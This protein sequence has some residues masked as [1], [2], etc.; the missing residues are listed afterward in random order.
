VTL[1]AV[2]N[3]QYEVSAIYNIWYADVTWNTRPLVYGLSGVVFD[4]P[5]TTALPYDINVTNI[6][7]NWANGTYTNYGFLVEDTDYIFPYAIE[8]RGAA[9]CGKEGAPL[10]QPPQLVITYQ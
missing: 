9:Y 5:I 2:Y 4:Q 6:V 10:C 7:Q 1:P 3:T 8:L